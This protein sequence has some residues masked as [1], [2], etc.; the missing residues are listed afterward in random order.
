MHPLIPDDCVFH[1]SADDTVLQG[2]QFRE[3]AAGKSRKRQNKMS[4][5]D[6]IYSFGTSYPGDLSMHNYHVFLQELEKQETGRIMDLATI[7]IL[8]DR[9]CGVPRYNKFRQLLHTPPVTTFEEVM[10]ELMT[11]TQFRRKNCAAYTTVA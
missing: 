5:T 2:C 4:M 6:I 10:G 7:G 3:I 8:Q 11:A 9:E 1:S